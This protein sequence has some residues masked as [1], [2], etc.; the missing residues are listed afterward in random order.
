MWSKVKNFNA[1][2][3]IFF[4][5]PVNIK[6]NFEKC[7][8]PGL[9]L[10]K[11]TSRVTLQYKKPQIPH[12]VF[13]TPLCL[14]SQFLPHA[15]CTQFCTYH[16]LSHFGDVSLTD[17]PTKAFCLSYP[18]IPLSFRLLR[19]MSPSPFLKLTPQLLLALSVTV[20]ATQRLFK[21]SFPLVLH[22]FLFL[23]EDADWT[24]LPLY[25]FCF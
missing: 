9:N 1:S 4:V 19:E 10:S 8:T 23:Y 25:F 3:C 2:L 17:S 20:L 24:I 7:Q 22:L 21:H 13:S 14:V 11:M 16:S 12:F 15:L 5:L 6:E 18:H